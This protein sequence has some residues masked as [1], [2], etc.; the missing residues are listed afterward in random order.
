[1]MLGF[2]CDPIVHVQLGTFHGRAP[3]ADNQILLNRSE[4]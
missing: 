2:E 1:M 3:V 4:Y